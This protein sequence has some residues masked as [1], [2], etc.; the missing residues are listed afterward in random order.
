MPYV[1]L[2][3][4]RDFP[5]ATLEQQIGSRDSTLARLLIQFSYYVFDMGY[6]AT[7]LVRVGNLVANLLDQ[8]TQKTRGQRPH[9]PVLDS[10]HL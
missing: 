9:V 2:D 6:G 4:C 8:L 1:D 5:P 3:R 7:K 10:G